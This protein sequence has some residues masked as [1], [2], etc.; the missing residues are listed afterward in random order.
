[1]VVICSCAPRTD[2]FE[3]RQQQ[4][5]QAS[6]PP[7]EEEVLALA[8]SLEEDARIYGDFADDG[9]REAFPAPPSE[10]KLGRRRG[11]NALRARSISA[12]GKPLIHLPTTN[13][14]PRQLDRA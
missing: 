11:V 1:M 6:R 5:E 10:P 4:H 7:S 2:P 9:S 13:G 12:G 14:S 3:K 8:I